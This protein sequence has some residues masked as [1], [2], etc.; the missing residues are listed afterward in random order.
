MTS[1]EV[2]CFDRDWP[3]IAAA[4]NGRPS[5]GVRPDDLAYVIYT[6]GSTGRPK[7]AMITQR[8]LSNYL[9]WAARAY[10]VAAGPGAPVHTSISFDLTVTALFL[11]LV[12]GGRVD[13]LCEGPGVEP[14]ADALR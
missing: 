8:G 7:G 1:A 13:L 5:A 9:S 11:P 14:L 4:P 6:S 3:E 10:D 2:V 12:T